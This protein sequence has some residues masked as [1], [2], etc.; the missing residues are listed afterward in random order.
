[1][2]HSQN[3][4]HNAWQSSIGKRFSGGLAFD[5]HY[6]WGKGLGVTGGVTGAY[7]RADASVDIQEF[8]NPRADRG[9]N[10]GDATHR[11]QAD[12]IYGPLWLS[13][14][15]NPFLRHVLGD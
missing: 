1:M 2:D 3:T 15:N 4:I 8:H 11:F 14:A 9:P 6:T 13:P 10:A 5:A 12:W 7:Y